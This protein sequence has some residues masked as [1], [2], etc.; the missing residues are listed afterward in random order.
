M[1]DLALIEQLLKVAHAANPPDNR[2]DDECD[3]QVTTPDGWT[4]EFFYDCGEL[5][6]IDHFVS[7]QGGRLEIWDGIDPRL[8]DGDGDGQW[9]T[10]RN[11]RGVDDTE[12]LLSHVRS[13]KL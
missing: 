2:D 9:A 13:R 3:V 7:P 8:D 11:W 12:R 5:D 10:L 1:A 6:Y 4:V